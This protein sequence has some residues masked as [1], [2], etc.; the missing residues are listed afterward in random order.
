VSTAPYPHSLLGLDPETYVPHALHADGRT[1]QETNCWTDVLIELL[2]ARGQEPLAAMGAALR[3]DFE[4][5]QWSFLKP[6]SDVLERLYGLDAHEMQPY[7]A[8]PLQA[9][10]QL[11]LGRSMIVELD[12]WFLPDTASTSYRHERVKT[13][14][15]IESIDVDGQRMRYFHNAGYHE[16]GPEDF[17]GV[18]HLDPVPDAQVLPPYTEIVRFDVGPAPEGDALRTV[19]RE[20]LPAHL[21]RRPRTNPFERFA[22]R[23]ADDLP[24]V[25]AGDDAAYHDYAFATVRMAGSSF[26]LAGSH[27]RWLLGDDGDAAADAL[28]A[29]VGDCKLLSFKLARRRAFDPE[30]VVGRMA[31]SW[32]TA[33]DHLDGLAG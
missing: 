16:L 19:A 9:A 30:P 5:D 29:I 20:L 10:E 32:R 22:V 7:R 1:Y 12:A 15:A 18:F 6:S 21:A 2:H 33:M 23:L 14:V 17:R 26:E 27:V 8:I 24:G 3:V 25:L 28:D 31:T 13:S 4:G 11:D